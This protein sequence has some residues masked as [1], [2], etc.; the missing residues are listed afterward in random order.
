MRIGAPTL[1]RIRNADARQKRDGLFLSLP[2]RHRVVRQDGLLD[3][4]PDTMH[5]VQTMHRILEDHRHR[6][7]AQT[8]QRG[9]VGACEVDAL[10]Q[11]GPL[12]NAGGRRQQTH[13][14]ET[15]QRFS[16]AAFADDCERLSGRDHG[17]HLLHRADHAVRGFDLDRKIADVEHRLPSIGKQTGRDEIEQ[18][19]APCAQRRAVRIEGVAQLV[20]ERIHG[21]DGQRQRDTGKQQQQ[22]RAVHDGARAA[23]HHAP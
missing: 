12:R 22:R 6:A 10:E 16:R 7:A 17:R 4:V 20:A 14:G 15:G 19:A 8:P 9:F 11:C 1:L 18:P 13:R 3:L 21:E 2:A 23:D 5:R